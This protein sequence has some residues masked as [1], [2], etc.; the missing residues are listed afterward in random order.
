MGI[1]GARMCKA[2]VGCL[3]P[4]N[5]PNSISGVAILRLWGSQCSSLGSSGAQAL[6]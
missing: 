6:S 2:M 3:A 1:K 4:E 5:C